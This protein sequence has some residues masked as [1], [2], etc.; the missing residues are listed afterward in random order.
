[1]TLPKT[2]IM[3]HRRVPTICAVAVAIYAA[4]APL[5]PLASTGRTASADRHYCRTNCSRWN[6][7]AN[8]PPL[9]WRRVFVTPVV[10]HRARRG[11]LAI[12]CPA[13]TGPWQ[14]IAVAPEGRY[15][16]RRR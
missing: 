10:H 14:G 9:L 7:R 2:A 1:M 16:A 5:V 6:V 8:R 4:I 15:A 13:S 3:D 11:Q 12:R